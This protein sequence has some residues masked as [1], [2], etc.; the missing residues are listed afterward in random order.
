MPLEAST[1]GG[2]EGVTYQPHPVGPPSIHPDNDPSGKASEVV[3]PHA[4]AGPRLSHDA[5][6]SRNSR[7]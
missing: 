4:P 7:K 5:P 1:P 3:M 2:K 6:G